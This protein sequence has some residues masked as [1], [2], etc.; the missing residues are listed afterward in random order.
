MQ[1]SGEKPQV[2]TAS[3]ARQ[4]FSAKPGAFPP[5]G[6]A[7]TPPPIPSAKPASPAYPVLAMKDLERKTIEGVVP[8]LE[9]SE[10]N[11]SRRRE[12]RQ[13]WASSLSAWAS[14]RWT[15]EMVLCFRRSAAPRGVLRRPIHDLGEYQE[16]WAGRAT[17]HKKSKAHSQRTSR[18]RRTLAPTTPLSPSWYI[19]GAPF[20]RGGLRAGHPTEIKARKKPSNRGVQWPTCQS[21]GREH[22][23]QND[24]TELC[25]SLDGRM[26]GKN[27]ALP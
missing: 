22:S 16:G 20:K 24:A 19:V 4:S 2:R 6:N 12:E 27:H 18:L 17:G 5:P 23:R 11:L 3:S 15:V 14:G 8:T 25:V 1:S 7:E 10:G 26:N 9:A 21:K 13:N